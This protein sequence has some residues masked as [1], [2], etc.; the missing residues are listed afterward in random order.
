[1]LIPQTNAKYKSPSAPNS[2]TAKNMDAT[3]QLVAPQNT[4]A[5][6]S[7]AANP[8]G[9][10]SSG[11]A[12][13]PKVAPTKNDGTTSPPLKPAPSVTAVKRILSKKAAGRTLPCSTA[14]V[15]ISM[16]APL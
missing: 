11:P 6:P 12:K 13:Q 5:N 4:A 14:A 3:G 9:I 10:P 2:S 1:M 16:P 15:M 8:A 7:A